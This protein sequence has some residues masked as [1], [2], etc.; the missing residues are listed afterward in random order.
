MIFTGELK[1]GFCKVLLMG[2]Y[3]FTVKEMMAQIKDELPLVFKRRDVIEKVQERFG[4]DVKESTI[5]A[6]V[7]AL[8]DHPSSKHYGMR[9]K[10][11][12]Y[13]GNGNFCT[14]ENYDKV[15]ET[16]NIPEHPEYISENYEEELDTTFTFEKDLQEFISRN[17]NSLEDGLTLLQ[18]EYP[19]DVG[20]LDILAKDKDGILVVIEL[21]VG[22]AKK[23]VLGQI[24]S[25]MASI[26]Q[27]KSVEKVRGIIVANDFDYALKLASSQIP[28]LKLVRYVVKFEFEEVEN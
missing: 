19:T 28:D 21:K 4:K 7:T 24:L 10:F 26:K 2:K 25:Y 14:I 18:K 12:R 5:A 15:V 27:K 3:Q 22:I 20:R 6:H 16:Y 11:F 9:E 17:L 13:L 8:S 1:Y 23:E